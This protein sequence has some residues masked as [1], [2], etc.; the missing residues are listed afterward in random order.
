MYKFS[1]C[2]ENSIQNGYITEKI[3]DCLYSNVLPIYL[4]AP[5]I[6]EYIEKKC[7]IDRNNFKS[8]EDL[9][10]Y[11]DSLNDK[12][13]E[14]Y[15]ENGKLFLNTSKAKFFTKDYCVSEFVKN[16]IENSKFK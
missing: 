6:N 15:I 3:F 8:N 5:N 7:F 1:I 13:Y 14:R 10:N 11:I 9:F 2:Y 12:E 4:G 16:I